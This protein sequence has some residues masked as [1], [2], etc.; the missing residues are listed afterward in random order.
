MP[1][2]L[3]KSM[4]MRT[5]WFPQPH[6]ISGTCSF[7]FD[8]GALD[9]T[10]V[11][12]AFY[13]EGLGA[14]GALETHPE[15]AAFAVIADQ[16][17]CFVNSRINS[18]FA[19]FQFS[20]SKDFI[21]DNIAAVRMA[22]MPIHCAFLEDYTA[23]DELSSATVS[24]V[25]ELQTESSDRQGGPL[26]VA[27][28]DLPE[29]VSGG[30]N[31]GVNTPFLDT[32]VGLE[33]VAFNSNSYYDAI[34]FLTIANKVRACSGGLRWFT[35]SQQKPYFRMRFNIV[36][37]V[38]RMNPFTYYGLLVHGPVAGDVA[39]LPALTELTVDTDYV[40]CD[41]QIRYNEWN[42]DFNFAKI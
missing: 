19:E 18:I 17:N 25:L 24:S 4:L 15:N 5:E 23:A 20:I 33:A 41:W 36:P 34:H 37:K 1:L 29:K 13:D 30:A 8:N 10:I 38:K 35:L 16:A 28:T 6:D 22:V 11:P 21:E 40:H 32:D 3:G 31:L 9:T 14:P 7:E 27:A 42:S 2:G 39:Q 12:I 26:Y